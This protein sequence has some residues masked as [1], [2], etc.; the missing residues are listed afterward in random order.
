M[1]VRMCVPDLETLF[2][3]SGNKLIGPFSKLGDL[4]IDRLHGLNYSLMAET[5][6][7]MIDA[8][9]MSYDGCIGSIQRN[10]SDIMFGFLAIPVMGPNLTHTVV[11]GSD[12]MAFMSAYMKVN[13]THD[14][15]FTDVLDMM[16]AFSP[17]LWIL[18][19]FFMAMIYSC[20]ALFLKMMRSND[21]TRFKKCN[22]ALIACVLKQYTS[23]GFTGDRF[24][25]MRLMFTAMTV[26][27]FYAG[28][29]LT[30]MIKTDMV[31]VK[32][33]ITVTT[34]DEL[35]K[36]GRRPL[37]IAVLTDAAEFENSK[38]GSQEREIW[39]IAVRM[40]INDFIISSSAD[41]IFQHAFN[42]AN[43]K[44]VCIFKSGLFDSV[45]MRAACEYSRTE[46]FQM[47]R[48]AIFRHDE[49]ARETLRGNIQNHI[50]DRQTSL[51]V[52]KRLQW[53]FESSLEKPTTSSFDW[54]NIYSMEQLNRNFRSIR[55]CYSNII[56]IPY[57][58]MTAVTLYHFMSL[59]LVTVTLFF[60]AFTIFLFEAIVRPF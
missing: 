56:T 55:E 31:V 46:G 2:E 18:L 30:S 20:H 59:I 41:S 21:G 7:N 23:G 57:P 15:S 54:T 60:V 47:D 13:L 27:S 44:E 28:F 35:I 1:A 52:N 11:D 39:E 12:K 25:C 36:S 4:I 29:Y 53:S 37:W 49:H 45:A 9:V 3:I 58:E 38:P 19:T 50:L 43:M 42:I 26:L 16:Y 17:G 48:N 32:P 10:E 33:P 14:S 8:E 22:D 6:G 40:G 24:C 5:A 34:Y 51:M